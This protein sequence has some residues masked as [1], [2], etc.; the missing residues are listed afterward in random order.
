M[1]IHARKSKG[2]SLIEMMVA[3]FIT[4]FTLLA[5][6]AALV[7]SVTVSLENELRSAAVRLTNQ[8]AEILLAL[9]VESINTCGITPEPNAPNY[10]A[11]YTYDNT[12]TCLG[13]LIDE[14]KKY[15][16]PVQS[17]KGFHQ[18]FNIVWTVSNLNG[19]LKQITI[20][21]VYK[22]SN[23]NH[24]NNAVIYKHRTL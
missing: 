23:E 6:S 18:N 21:V 9:P 22:H 13:T 4:A 19:N 20:A 16:N 3:L 11:S 24:T 5:L 17:I 7:S 10:D 8:T 12:N 2:F 15:P 1:E 14:Y